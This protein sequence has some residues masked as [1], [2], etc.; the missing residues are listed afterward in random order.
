MRKVSAFLL[1]IALFVAPLAMAD[2]G[3]CSNL[4]RVVEDYLIAKHPRDRGMMRVAVFDA[5]KRQWL[6]FQWDGRQAIEVTKTGIDASFNNDATLLVGRSDDVAVLVAHAN[7]LLYSTEVTSVSRADIQGLADLQKLA[8]VFGTD[9]QSILTRTSLTPDQ[10]ANNPIAPLEAT[11]FTASIQAMGHS[12]KMIDAPGV[13]K[14][15]RKPL[16]ELVVA[17]LDALRPINETLKDAVDTASRPIGAAKD[18]PLEIADLRQ[19][20]VEGLQGVELGTALDAKNVQDL[21]K[22]RTTTTGIFDNSAAA[23]E[24]L[25]TV[26]PVCSAPVTSLETALRLVIDPLPKDPDEAADIRNALRK[27]LLALR[28]TAL[29]EGCPTKDKE[30]NAAATS[31]LHNAM[32]EL[33]TWLED[34]QNRAT[35]VDDA[36]NTLLE[37]A[38]SASAKYI[39]AVGKR[40]GLLDAEDTIEE[41]R[42]ATIKA[43]TEL[44]RFG[45]LF[46]ESSIQGST[47]WQTSGIVEVDRAQK[48][49]LTLPWYEVQTEEYSVKVR[50][51]F[52]QDVLRILPDEV[53][54]KYTFSRGNYRLGVDTAL[55][56]THANDREYKAA[57]EPVN[58]D[59]NDDGK[60]NKDDTKPFVREISR[61]DRSGKFALML[62]ASPEFL[63]GFGL[64]F[65]LGIDT[66]NPAAFLGVTRSFGKF[67]RISAGHTQQRVT[68][69]GTGVNIGDELKSADALRTRERFDASWYAAVA[70]TISKLPIFK[71]SD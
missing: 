16:D 11:D 28:P 14:T 61:T 40:A 34:P 49:G 54:G 23:A 1:T 4:Q 15:R 59:L 5:E 55:I 25:A 50:P 58:E 41:K 13:M 47:C 70:F 62:T 30:G 48:N 12:M 27:A 52:A 10:V 60:I 21:P 53:K 44:Q 69:L 22:L 32:S 26:K 66:D 65:G 71:T 56:Y 64:Q 39:A 17:Y 33:I 51:Q 2:Y 31:P 45:T 35:S 29:E 68:R 24:A 18:Q 9:L 7:P 67:I 20:I 3:P 6:A 43:A 63:H 42:A 38:R 19:K 8:G 57:A 37:D 46:Q 36:V